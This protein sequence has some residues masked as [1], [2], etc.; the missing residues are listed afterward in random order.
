[1]RYDEQTLRPA[2]GAAFEQGGLDAVCRL[3]V[4]LLNEQE[5]RHQ[6]EL[7]AL[8]ARHQAVI[9]KLEARIAELE[10]RLNKN[11]S[12]SSKP[13][14]SDGLK[15]TTS[16]RRKNT[17]RKPG[18]QPGHPGQT[19]RRSETPDIIFSEPLEQ[20]PECGADLS[21]QPVVG[22]EKRQVFDLPPVKIQVT[23]HQ[24]ER[25]MCPNCGRIVSAIFPADVCA[26]TQY[27]PVMQAVMA[28]L[29]VRQV[30]PCERVAEVCEDLFGHRPSA[31][32]VVQ[33]VVRCAERVA[34]AVDEIRAALKSS[35]I[36]HAD[37]TGVRCIGK[38]HWLHVA[39]NATHTLYSHSPKRGVE[40]FEVAGVLPGYTGMAVHDFWGPYDILNCEHAR[41]NAHLLRELKAFSEAGR[42]WATHLI[43]TLLAMKEAADEARQ[44]GRTGINKTK[45]RR[46]ETLYDKWVKAGQK[47]HPEQFK[48][49]GQRGRAKQSPE[50]NLLRRLRD[51]REE[52]L[53]FLHD[54]KVPFDNNQAERDLRM[55]KVQQKVSGCFRSEDGAKRFCDFSSYISTVRKLGLNL[56]ASIKSALTGAPASLTT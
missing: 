33:A 17:G 42:A 40:G 3:V 38:T 41:C 19:L 14:S 9:A 55:I 23:E 54:L 24:A 15:R 31:G 26:P 39:S 5:A 10:K 30:I 13:P 18:G 48:P 43:S 51:K 28:Y 7:V 4:N 49:T 21:A 50:Y 34:P 11:S 36:L 27:G 6:A 2:I 16:Q 56:I 37:E 45:R 32:S 12:N 47:A 22:E 53:R 20:C 46:L 8:E 25:K 29:N 44:N 52:V 1:M 35:P